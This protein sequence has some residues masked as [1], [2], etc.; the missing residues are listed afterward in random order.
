[1]NRV[2]S[3]FLA[4]LPVQSSTS[5]IRSPEHTYAVG[6]QRLAEIFQDPSIAQRQPVDI[7]FSMLSPEKVNEVA[8][9]LSHFEKDQDKALTA[10][11]SDGKPIKKLL[12]VCA[13]N[14]VSS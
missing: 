3:T 13:R 2:Y 4:R 8:A 6:L 9:I 5:L 1:M 12:S 7:S 14:I 10:L 11:G